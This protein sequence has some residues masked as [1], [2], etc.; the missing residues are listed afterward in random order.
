MLKV[1]LFDCMINEYY[2]SVDWRRDICPLFCPRRG[3]F[4]SL[5]ILTIQGIKMLST[6]TVQC[7]NNQSLFLLF[8]IIALVFFG[9]RV[10]PHFSSGIVERAKRER[11]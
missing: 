11:A 7:R 6:V 3:V 10:V 1:A 8:C 5:S 9:L 2:C 4:G